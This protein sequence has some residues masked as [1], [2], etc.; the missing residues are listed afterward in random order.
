MRGLHE[1]RVQTTKEQSAVWLTVYAWELHGAYFSGG[2]IKLNPEV[3]SA[4]FEQ[5]SKGRG[6][7][8]RD[9]GPAS[10]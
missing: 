7:I 2:N 4:C 3:A 6:M 10:K 1:S 8:S 9:A 5:K